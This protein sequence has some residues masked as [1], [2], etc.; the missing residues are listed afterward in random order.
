MPAERVVL[1]ASQVPSE[2][3][4]PNSGPRKFS[5]HRP[6]QIENRNS[7]IPQ[8]TNPTLE[9]MK[10][11]NRNPILL[12][13]AFLAAFCSVHAAEKLVWTDGHGDV[14]VNYANG[15]WLWYAE[16]GKE[17]DQVIIRLNDVGRNQIP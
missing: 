10:S 5:V 2:A 9:T 11:E 12:I 8:T 13:A 17:V 1:G 15:T 4:L 14:A 6:I 7:P 16:E 3:F